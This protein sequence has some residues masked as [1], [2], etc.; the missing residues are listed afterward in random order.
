MRPL[1]PLLLLLSFASCNAAQ[2]AVLEKFGI[3]KRD[4]LVDRVEEGREDQ[5]A[6]KEQIQTTFEAFQELTGFEGGDVGAVYGKLKKEFERSEDRAEKVSSR[7]ESIEQVAG[8]MFREWKAEIDGMT[9]PKLK[10]KSSDLRRDTEKRYAMVLDSMRTAESKMQPVLES[11]RNHV[12]FL[13]HSLNAAAISSLK[14]DALAIESDVADLI[15]DMQQSI[16]EADA[17]I[18]SLEGPEA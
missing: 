1:I 8:D 17:F 5:A 3:D 10:S 14:D 4:I 6:A 12:L 9:D 18:E 11:F 15:R 2:Y 16:D 7:I 13:K